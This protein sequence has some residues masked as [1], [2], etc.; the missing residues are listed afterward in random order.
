MRIARIF[1]YPIR[2][3]SGVEVRDAFLD[4]SGIVDDHLLTLVHA[5]S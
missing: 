2:S 5:N 3:C 1:Y 4:T